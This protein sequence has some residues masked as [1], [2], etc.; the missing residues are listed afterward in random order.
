MVLCFGQ[1]K[2]ERGIDTLIRAFALLLHER[3][4]VRL[5]IAG[6]EWNEHFGSYQELARELGVQ[7]NLIARIEYLPDEVVWLIFFCRPISLSY[8]I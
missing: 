3:P 8:R 1:I 7:H 6:P 5:V 4:N 2:K